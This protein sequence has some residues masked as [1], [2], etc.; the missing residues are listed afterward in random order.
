MNGR[1]TRELTYHGS[2]ARYADQRGEEEYGV[3][4]ITSFSQ[5]PMCSLEEKNILMMQLMP[6]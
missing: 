5:E 1:V 4:P 3:Q 2:G 6:C